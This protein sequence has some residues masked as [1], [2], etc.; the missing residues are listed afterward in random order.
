MP[1]MVATGSDGDRPSLGTTSIMVC[2]GTEQAG[3]W[4]K[5]GGKVMQAACRVNRAPLFLFHLFCLR[6]KPGRPQ[7]RLLNSRKLGVVMFEVSPSL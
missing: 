4:G 1:G 2:T 5:V 6:P 7:I 3:E